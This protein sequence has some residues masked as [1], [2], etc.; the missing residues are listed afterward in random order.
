MT[1]V[2]VLE[3]TT[4]QI[5]INLVYLVSILLFIGGLK[6]MS[7]ARTAR[8]GNQMSAMGML[9]AVM[10]ALFEYDVQNILWIVGGVA[11]GA[12]IG[13]TFALRVQMTKMPELVALFNGLGGG[14]SALVAGAAMGEGA[15]VVSGLVVGITVVVGTMTMTGS[16]VA[17][18]KL[19][20]FIN[21]GA[22]GFPG[23]KAVN[24]VLALALATG[25]VAVAFGAGPV[26]L[27]VV[28]AG[29]AIFGLSSVFPIGGG[30][31]PVVISLLNSLSGVAASA[32]GFVLGNYVLI[33]SGALVGASGI[34][35]TNIMCVA[36]NRSL[37]NVLFSGFGGA[38][39]AGKI[40]KRTAK[41]YSV[42]DAI[43]QLENAS[44]VVMV[45]GYGL[46][47]AR[48]QHS[49]KELGRILEERDIEVRYAIHPVAGRMPG[50]MNVLLAEAEV[51]YE[52]LKEMEEINPEFE[53][54]DVV[55]VVGANDVVNPAAKEDEESPIFGMPILD[56]DR[57]RKC[58]I[59]KRSLSP[60]FAGI[61]NDLFYRD[62][63][64]MIFGDAKDTLVN[65]VNEAK[66]QLS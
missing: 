13:V 60:G 43:I 22:V 19:G 6:G 9:V 15:G 36:M 33:V 45:P 17:F 30:D 11:I 20:D 14:A 42:D 56:V 41:S 65:L 10:A 25:I 54:T 57:A 4:R 34:I 37:A 23:Q 26:W 61:D 55:L 24:L 44:S 35:L 46:A 50:H 40:E 39:G 49:L 31:M 8:R 62:N 38:A 59:L 66:T 63:T 52:A 12:L 29:A 18:G 51:D 58:I 21:S 64:M 16:L 1:D 53:T 7:S 47:V 5:V 32:A 3:F 48:A 27:A 2:S 28:V